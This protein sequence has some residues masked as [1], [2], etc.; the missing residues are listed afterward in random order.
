MT[1][2]VL[3]CEAFDNGIRQRPDGPGRLTDY[4]NVIKPLN[5]LKLGIP[6]L[7]SRHPGK[8]LKDNPSARDKTK[9]GEGFVPGR[10]QIRRKI[11]Y[12]LPINFQNLM[13]R[14]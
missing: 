8:R 6:L 3:E 7:Q 14:L 4:T 1:N 2:R 12:D 5:P 9:T 11:N 13:A 10:D